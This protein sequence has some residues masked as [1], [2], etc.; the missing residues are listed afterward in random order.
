MSN[1]WSRNHRA[2]ALFP[3]PLTT[4][5]D[6]NSVPPLPADPQD[7][8]QYL[9]LSPSIS[10]TPQSSRH[11]PS[12]SVTPQSSRYSPLPTAAIV[13]QVTA[14]S[15]PDTEM[16]MVDKTAVVL[17]PTEISTMSNVAGSKST[18]ADKVSTENYT[19]LKPKFSSALHTNR[20]SSS[21]LA[22]LKPTSSTSPQKSTENL[23]AN[24]A[25]ILP[26]P[27]T[28]KLQQSPHPISE[29][30]PTPF[31]PSYQNPN[32]NP[33]QIPNPFTTS[34]PTFVEKIRR[35]EDKT[36]KRL[37]PLQFSETRRLRVLIP[38]EV[39]QKG[40]DLHKDFIVWYFK[41]RPP[42][43]SHIKSVLNHMWG[44]GKRLE[45]HN[46]PITR[47]VLWTSAHS[48]QS[49]SLQSI[50]IWAHLH[51]VPLDLRHT[52]GLSLV[53]GL[54]GEP[55]E[56]NDFTKNLVSL[57]LSHVKVEVDLTKPLPSIVEF[58]RQSGEVVEVLVTY[59]WL[60]PTCSHCK[61]LG[62]IVKNCLHIP[63]TKPPPPA[64][65]EKTNNQTKEVNKSG[66]PT[67][68]DKPKEVRQSRTPTK[69]ASLQ[70]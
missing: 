69:Q 48:D 18:V 21:P 4:G 58:T 47:S 2:S 57:T 62:H 11:S 7:L 26:P 35:S 13:P 28:N 63:L 45:I 67:K 65:K 60:P 14:S 50:Q 12:I 37:A 3:P 16:V 34:N 61:E 27:A 30:A 42:P 55:K 46:N 41:G 29:Q 25:P 19:I 1:P 64:S 44:K 22:P 23:F 51:G 43:Y 36:L 59:P 5:D 56:T 40:A 10:V 49:P 70:S 9:P 6:R 31:Q 66:T 17:D 53:A 52:Y 54:V 8:A 39:F 38:D 20:A 68:T 15:P 32:P 33:N 24:S